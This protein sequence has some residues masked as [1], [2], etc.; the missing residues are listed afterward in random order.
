MAMANWRKQQ[1][2][3]HHHVGHWRSSSYNRKPPL[4]T[5]HSTVPSW[6]KKFCFTVGSVPWR[7]LIESKKYMYLH[8]NVINWDDSAVKE[9]FDNAKS[10]FWAE[11]NGL[12]CNI[13]L[14]DPNSYIDNVD[15]N[16]SVDP[17]LVLDLER[18]VKVPSEGERDEEVVILGSPFL[19][20]QQSFSCTGWGD[21]EAVVPK[22]SD[23]NSA[24][25]GWD[26]NVHENNGVDS[27]EQH[28]APVEQAKEYEWQHRQNDLWGWNQREHFG[29]DMHKLSKGRNGGNGNWGAWDGYNR[30]RE[31]MS[32]SKSHAYNGNEYHVNRGRRNNRGGRRGSFAYDRPYVD[33]VPSPTAW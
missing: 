19:L 12:P 32:W 28:Y 14:P 20:N 8:D 24:D 30:R 18:E 16:S 17:E 25:Q 10:R 33:K 6:E 31:N 11:I 27:W 21:D 26:S 5:W 3:S 9:A 4:D 1:A 13:S 2:E 7:K 23:P 29:G 15:W 22:A